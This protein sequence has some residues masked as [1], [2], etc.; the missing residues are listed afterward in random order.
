MVQGVISAEKKEPFTVESVNKLVFVG[1]V[2]YVAPVHAVL[3]S[4]PP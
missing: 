2:E 4:V 3:E 1:V